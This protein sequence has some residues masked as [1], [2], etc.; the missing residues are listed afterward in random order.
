MSYAVITPVTDEREPLV[1]AP[2][3][4]WILSTL[5]VAIKDKRDALFLLTFPSYALDRQPGAPAHDE[6]YWAPP[7]VAY[8]V[9]LMYSP[10]TTVGSV[11]KLI[12]ES[13]QKISLQGDLAH[14]CYQMGLRDVLLERREEF[15]ELKVSPRSPS[16]IK[17]YY[18]VRH[19]LISADAACLRNLA[20]PEVRRGYVYLPIEEERGVAPS[21]RFCAAHGR[22]EAWFLGKP[23]QS[24]VQYVLSSPERRTAIAA[25]SL[26]ID[27][28]LFARKE[29]GIVCVADLAGYG[30]LL[31]YAGDVMHSFREAGSQA[32][33]FFR[34]EVAEQFQM[35]LGELGVTQLQ[36]A[37]DGFI[38]AF[39]SRVFA[40]AEETRNQIAI[41]WNELLKQIE[42]LNKSVREASRKVGSRLVLHYGKYRF[43]RIGGPRSFSPAFD[44]DTIITAARLEQGLGALMKSRGTADGDTSKHVIL[45]SEE[46]VLLACG[47]DLPICWRSLTS[48]SLT[49]KEFCGSGKLYERMAE[50]AMPA[51]PT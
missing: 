16:L 7:F 2:S 24:N 11:R 17:A 1:A 34:Q 26:E 48:V 27:E 19:G 18:I 33:D 23:L 8:P 44:G 29:I 25:K 36:T 39:P 22:D 5:E 10:P 35:M 47:K 4:I 21:K 31:K 45:E 40:S 28:S 50:V 13:L 43:G 32:Q 3:A 12:G 20:D 30:S 9:P 37:G 6:G 51:V 46:L 49:A 14:L 38:A 15:L 41:R 42:N